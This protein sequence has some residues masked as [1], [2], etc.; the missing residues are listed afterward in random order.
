MPRQIQAA[1]NELAESHKPASVRTYY[2]TLRALLGDAVDLDIIGRSPCRGIKLPRASDEEKRVVSPADLH[3]LAEHIEPRYRPVIYLAGVMGL[4]FGEAIGLR[5]CDLDVEQQRISVRQ[6]VSEIGGRISIGRPKTQSSVRTLAAPNRLMD[7]LIQHVHDESVATAQ[8]LL[9]TDSG[10]GAIRRTNFRVR[11]FDPAVTAAKL[12]GLTFHGLRHSAATQWVADGIDSRTAQ[13]R[14]GH[15]DPRL[16][17]KLYAHASTPADE[18][19]ANISDES[20]WP[21]DG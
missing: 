13:Q 6:T 3:R 14:L 9:F 18:R 7:M 21:S 1:V 20:Y 8:A 12:D 17:L 4:R 19:A 2:G 16:I 5:L 11:V 15:S 10:G